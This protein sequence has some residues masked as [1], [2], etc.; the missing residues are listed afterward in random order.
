ME[1]RHLITFQT[2]VEIGSYSGAASKLGYTQ[3]TITFHIQACKKKLAAYT[4]REIPAQY[5]KY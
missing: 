1:I 3:S 5:L 4:L 2:I